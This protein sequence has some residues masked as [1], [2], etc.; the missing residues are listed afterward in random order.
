MIVSMK[1]DERV[2]S[3]VLIFVIPYLVLKYLDCLNL[4]SATDATARFPGL[5]HFGRF[6]HQTADGEV[7]PSRVDRIG[8]DILRLQPRVSLDDRF[9]AATCRRHGK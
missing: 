4:Q 1:F 9:H 7:V 8:L 3:D 2:D 6:S 5:V